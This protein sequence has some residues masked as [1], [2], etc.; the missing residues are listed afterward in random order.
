ML[1]VEE[2]SVTQPLVTKK[3]SGSTECEQDPADLKRALHFLTEKRKSTRNQQSILR[4]RA[5]SKHLS[6]LRLLQAEQPS[7]VKQGASFHERR[8]RKASAS[9]NDEQTE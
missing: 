9:V 4:K 7:L 1:E 8:L 2:I 3:T 5:E 6:C